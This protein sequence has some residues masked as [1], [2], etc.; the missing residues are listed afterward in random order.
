MVVENIAERKDAVVSLHFFFNFVDGEWKLFFGI[1]G[2]GFSICWGMVMNILMYNDLISRLAIALFFIFT[3]RIP[4]I[5]SPRELICDMFLGTKLGFFR[6]LYIICG[7]HCCSYVYVYVCVCLCLCVC[8]WFVISNTTFALI[9][10]NNA[11]E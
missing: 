5:K 11:C 9:H 8:V 7:V 6:W 3:F 2:C 10:H 1:F 4:R